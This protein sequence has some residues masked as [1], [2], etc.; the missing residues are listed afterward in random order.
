MINTSHNTAMGV[1]ENR[2]QAQQAVR[3]LKE[4]GFSDDQI[5]VIMRDSTEEGG[6]LASEH[7]NYASEGAVAG[8][9]TGM[10][11]GALWALG[12]AAGILPAIGPAIAGGILASLLTS[13]AAGA[14]VGGLAGSLVGL[15]LP[16]EEA[17][18]YESEFESGKTVVTVRAGDRFAEASDILRRFQAYNFN[19]RSTSQTMQTNTAGQTAAMAGGIESPA[20]Q[21]AGARTVPPGSCHVEPA[22]S[23]RPAR[24]LAA[25]F[26]DIAHG[27]S[28]PFHAKNL[29]GTYGSPTSSSHVGSG[30][31]G[32]GHESQTVD[33]PVHSE[34]MINPDSTAGGA[35]ASEVGD[36]IRVPVAEE[37]LHLQK[38]SASA[39]TQSAG[40]GVKQ[41]RRK[42]ATKAP[43]DTAKESRDDLESLDQ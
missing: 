5:G 8:A 21:P 25:G 41:G 22:A 16:E 20:C 4:A 39:S 14:A 30:G 31:S 11:V 43:H 1:F 35:P 24:G 27:S 15:G 17:E 2:L 12:I 23:E 42:K 37:E 29:A 26:A 33:V 28:E 18:F 9:A 7:Q 19:Q 10:G 40:K 38:E 32:T 6:T 3:E 36:E 34:E 13:A